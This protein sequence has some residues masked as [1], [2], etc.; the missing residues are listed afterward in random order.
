VGIKPGQ[1]LIQFSKGEVPKPPEDGW[2]VGIRPNLRRRDGTV[3]PVDVIH[4][5][6]GVWVNMSRKD[7]TSPHL[8]ERF[9]PAG[10][11]KTGMQLPAGFGYRYRASDNW[12]INYMI[13][14]LTE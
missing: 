8:P 14:N 13:H 6:H 11:E 12:L 4:L 5:H 2:I 10:E 1:T 7:V 9:L 3:P